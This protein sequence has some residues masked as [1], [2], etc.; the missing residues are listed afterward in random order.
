MDTQNGNLVF[1]FILAL[2]LSWLIAN[3]LGR[4]RHIGFG[5]SFFF[6]LVYTPFLG[7][8]I[9]L[10]SRKVDKPY[11]EPSKLKNIIGIIFMLFGIIA[12]ILLFAS[13]FENPEILYLFKGR[14]GLVFNHSI[15]LTGLGYY[16]IQRSKGR[17]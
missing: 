14:I 10:L 1:P 17:S 4:K 9:T 3:S 11:P 12:I 16:L 2:I 7:F 5:W 6:S 8:F 13:I 15:G